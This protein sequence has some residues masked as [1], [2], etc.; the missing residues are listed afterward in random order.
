M[1]LRPGEPV[2]STLRDWVQACGSCGAAAW[3]L[4]AL[5]PT[6][7]TVIDS[8]PYRSLSLEAAEDTLLFRRWAM[9]CQAGHDAESTAEATLMAAWAADDAADMAEAAKL[10]RDVAA[11]WGAPADLPTA[12]RRLDVLRRAGEFGAVETQAQQLAARPLNEFAGAVVAFQRDR[13]AARDASRHLLNS[14]TPHHILP[15]DLPMPKFWEL[16]FAG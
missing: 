3:N 5:P 1:D 12:L 6:A 15:D 9:I 11:L 4:S 14:A 16:L 8:A 10:R 2:R 13:A 7:K